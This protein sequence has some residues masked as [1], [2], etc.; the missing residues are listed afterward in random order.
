M[1]DQPPLHVVAE[2]K[3]DGR[4]DIGAWTNEVFADLA[5]ALGELADAHDAGLTGHRIYQ[6]RPCR[7]LVFLPTG[8]TQ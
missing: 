6:L 2:I 7:S 5:D 8:G 3:S 1:I 4:L